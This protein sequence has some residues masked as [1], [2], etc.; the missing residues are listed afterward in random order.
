MNSPA[1]SIHEGYKIILNSIS[2][3]QRGKQSKAIDQRKL[4]LARTNA[5]QSLLWFYAASGSQPAAMT[6]TDNNQ[7]N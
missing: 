3:L 1:T 7:D 6:D 5:E 2:E 4:A